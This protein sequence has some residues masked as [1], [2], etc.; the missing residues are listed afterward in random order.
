MHTN[1][2]NNILESALAR[3]C[4]Q[5]GLA[6]RAITTPQ[7][8]SWIEIPWGTSNQRLAVMVTPRLTEASLA[9]AAQL[10]AA[11]KPIYCTRYVPPA[12]A[13]W[14]R[15]RD[16]FFVDTTGNGY[17]NAP[18][19]FIFVKGN[20]PDQ[21]L[22]AE[23]TRRAFHPAGLKVI[24]P[25]LTQPGLERRPYREIAA[26]AQVALGTVNTVLRDLKALGYFTQHG[27]RDR[28]L[29]NREEL[30]R[31]WLT[32]YLEQLRPKLHLGRFHTPDVNW[33]QKM[34]PRR[35]QVLWSGEV[36]AA[37]ITGHLKPSNVTLYAAQLPEQLLIDHRLRRDNQ[38]DTE[39]LRSFWPQVV[40]EQTETV[41]PLLVYADLLASGDDRNRET[42][43]L[44]WE[45]DLARLIA[46]D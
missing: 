32:G 34:D 10:Q 36:A 24:Y 13:D 38:G 37:K 9:L 23:T 26:T 16:V 5:T 44:I 14:L 31:R 29:R 33:W 27:K 40:T 35:Y 41:H 1:D 2:E 15:E 8:D 17:I 19:L 20:R 45:H 3:L 46:E 7:G 43:G 11:A 39:I 30:L 42:A 4:K 21:P 25:L 22:P 18:P 28:V 6:A 12:Q